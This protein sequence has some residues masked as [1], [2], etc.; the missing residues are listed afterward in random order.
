MKLPQFLAALGVDGLEPPIHGP[1]K[2]DVAGG[3][4]RSA[5]NRKTL[6]DRPHLGAL[7][8]VPRHEFA[9]IPAGAGI[10]V[11]RSRRHR[12][13]RRCSPPR[14]SENSCTN[15]GAARRATACAAT[16][17]LAA[18]PLRPACRTD[19]LDSLM[20]AG[21]ECLVE[22]RRPLCRSINSM[23]LTVSYVS[24]EITSPVARSIT[25]MKPLRPGWTMTFRVWLSIF[26][27]RTMFSLI[28]S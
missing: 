2:D 11:E 9:A 5:P 14:W 13:C 20:D 4:E 15:V 1:V 17:R 16:T 8:R 21:R 23:V 7:D 26:R 10:H 6:L 22:D 28:S 25:Y 27:S 19:V 3:G 24:A 18:N 12:A